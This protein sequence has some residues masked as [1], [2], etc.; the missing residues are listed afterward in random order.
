MRAGTLRAGNAAAG[1][2]EEVRLE[3]HITGWVSF[4]K[5]AGSEAHLMVGA[6]MV[7]WR[8]MEPRGGGS[9]PNLQLSP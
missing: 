8:R 2:Q 5:K 1:S 7:N 3:H 9:H 6:A 4:W